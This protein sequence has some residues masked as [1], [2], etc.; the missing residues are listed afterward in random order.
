MV[1]IDSRSLDEEWETPDVCLQLQGKIVRR[2]LRALGTAG[3]AEK[4]DRKTVTSGVGEAVRS[5][6]A[7]W[8]VGEEIR[9]GSRYKEISWDSEQ[10]VRLKGDQR[11]IW[12]QGRGHKELRG[13]PAEESRSEERIGYQRGYLEFRGAEESGLQQSSGARAFLQGLQCAAEAASG[14]SRGEEDRLDVLVEDDYLKWY[15]EFIRAVRKRGFRRRTS[16]NI[17][18]W[19]QECVNRD[20]Q[21]ASEKLKECEAEAVNLC[22]M[23]QSDRVSKADSSEA[24]AS[25]STSPT[26]A[27]GAE[28]LP[29]NSRDSSLAPSTTYQETRETKRLTRMPKIT[30]EFV[31][32]QG[33]EA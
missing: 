12:A 9:R 8:S 15:Y 22:E 31:G 33:V 5:R 1:T 16:S 11:V 18:E 4:I 3:K 32:V 26:R 2:Q 13:I 24:G 28:T 6:R 7:Q 23:M 17:E 21:E 29:Y 14:L 27:T 10:G 25:S 30:E 19:T 20:E